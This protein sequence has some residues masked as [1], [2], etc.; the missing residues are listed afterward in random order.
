[1]ILLPLTRPVF[2]ALEP[3]D[4]RKSFDALF[5]VAREQLGH[6]AMRSAVVL[7][8]SRSR[9]HCK[10][11]FHDGSGF[12]LLYKRLDAR[13]FVVPTATSP[14]QRSVPVPLTELAVWL[15]GRAKK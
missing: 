14:E 7:F 1:M 4:M 12:V 11:L 6:D 15:Q 8:F 10:M 2:A 13:W 3:V 5:D 9:T